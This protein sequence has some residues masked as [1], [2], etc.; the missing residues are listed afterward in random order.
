[1]DAPCFQSFARKTPEATA[2]I[3]PDGRVW[4]RGALAALINRLSHALGSSDIHE[5][6]VAAIVAPNCVE[7][8]AVYLACLECGLFV[9]PINWRLGVNEVRFVLEDAGARLIIVHE[10]VS[11]ETLSPIH[12]RLRDGATVL[13]IG[14]IPG[15]TSLQSYVE[16]H[17][18]VPRASVTTGR[19][20]AYTSATTG[21]PKGVVLPL[22]NAEAALRKFIAWYHSLGIELED[23]NVN[24]CCTPLYHAAPLLSTSN[25]LQMGHA[26]VLVERWHPVQLLELIERYR[27]TTTFLVPTMFV[28]LLKLDQSVRERYSTNSLRFVMHSGAPCPV[29]TKRSMV[30]WWGNVIW[31]SYG[32]TEGQGT[33]VSAEEWLRF[34]GT[35]GRPIPGSAIRILNDRKEQLSAG[36]V[37]TIYLRP[38][39]GDRFEYKGDPEKTRRSYWG[40]YITVDDIGYV[41]D[42]GYLFICDRASDLILT[43]G[44][45]IYPAEIESCLIQHPEVADCAV[46]GVPHEI[47]GAVPIAYVQTRASESGDQELM[48]RLLHFLRGHLSA[49][50]LPHRITFVASIPRDSNGKL[51]K[52]RLREAL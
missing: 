7:F 38:Y 13:S 6:D 17:P 28:R 30:E 23:G 44:M 48:A 31:E 49:A 18:A 19:L 24:L 40:D 32:A 12:E 25:A 42:E 36:Q 27:V 41:N 39:T 1:M 16:G 8:L 45:N 9:V 22:S 11:E 4:S 50:K 26:V 3:D 2:V 37:G 33:I 35:V 34:P 51:Y 14:V 21:L 43:G 5:G 47:L 15:L 46:F 20:M 52:R 29:D 10:R